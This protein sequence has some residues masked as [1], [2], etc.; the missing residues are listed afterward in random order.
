VF[1]RGERHKSEAAR[2]EALDAKFAAISRSQAVIE[3]RPDGTIVAAN[4]NFLGAMGYSLDEIVGKHHA[5]FMDPAEAATPDYRAFWRRLNEG[6]FVATK[7]RRLAKGGR[8]VWIQASYNPIRDGEGRT[9]GVLKLATDITEAEQTARRNEAERLTGERTQ[10]AVVG[11]LAEGLARVSRGD[12]TARIDAPFEGAYAAVRDDFNTAVESLRAALLAIDELAEPVRSGADEIAHAADDLSKRTEQQAATLEETAAALDEV[13]ATVRQSADGAREAAQVASGAKSQAERSG[14]VVR[15]AIAAMG[16]IEESSGHIGR[17]IGVIDEIAFQTNLL[18]LNAGIEAAR[19]GD[20]G[21][22]FA[23]V[24]QEVRA[25]AGRSAE[26][27]QEI[28]GLIAASADHVGRGA[29]LVGTTGEALGDLM[30]S[31]GQI[32]AL[33]AEIARSAGEQSTALAEVNTAVNQM[34]TVTQRNAAMVEETSAAAAG[35]Q[36][37]G[38]A[39]SKAVAR[40]DLGRSKQAGPRLRMAG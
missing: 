4:E 11:A 34:D 14:E 3:F 12:L 24:A 36:A 18:A 16:A 15:Q 1:G 27:A 31:A 23:V 35:L 21:K 20:A 29:K 5:I 32:D 19:A 8:E 22:G 2:V 37:Q 9:I 28:K 13:T 26:A 6:E 38:D 39:L 33:L 7:F 17:I 40:F 30:Q 10:A 25:L